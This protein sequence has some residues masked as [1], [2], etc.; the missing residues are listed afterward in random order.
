M[1]FLL[2]LAFD[3]ARMPSRRTR[4]SIPA[5]SIPEPQRH[6]STEPRVVPSAEVGLV[7]RPA[8]ASARGLPDTG[9]LR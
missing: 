3:V 2:S 8:A 6:M 5:Q 7:E 9:Q 1:P 4:S